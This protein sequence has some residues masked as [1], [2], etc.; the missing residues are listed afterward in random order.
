MTERTC[1]LDVQPFLQTASVE[2][3]TA[4]RDHSTV[5]VLVADST[6]VIVLLQL[7]TTGCREAFDLVDSISPEQETL[8]A[9]LG[10]EPDVIVRVDQ[11]DGAAHHTP[12]PKHG[13]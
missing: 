2:E 8:P 10:S 1:F 5:H 4:R 11:D 6:D 12:L 9:E 13:L 7:C 3:M